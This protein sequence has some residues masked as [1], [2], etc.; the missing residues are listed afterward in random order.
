MKSR[1]KYIL[2]YFVFWVLVF[3]S[4]KPLFLLFH[5]ALSSD[6]SF[7][8]WTQV[9]FSGLSM[10]MSMS[11]YLLIPVLLFALVSCFIGCGK[12]F[13][14]S[15]QWFTLSML[16]VC[17]F[18]FSVDLFLYSYWGFRLDCTPLF[19][20]QSPKNA[21]AS[22]TA[23]EYAFCSLLFVLMLWGYVKLFKSIHN[24]FCPSEGKNYAYLPMVLLFI[25]LSVVTIRGGV[26]VS[27]MNVGRVYFS[28]HTF[29]N[30]AAIN[31][32]WN[33]FN[34]L[35]K[36]ED[37]VSDYRFMDDD[38]ANEIFDSLMI[39]SKSPSDTIVLNTSRPNIIFIV[40]ESFG[41]NVCEVVGG[42]PKLTPNLDKIAKEGLLFTHFYANSYRTDRGLVSIFSSYPGQPVT[43]LMKYPNKS[44]NVPTLPKELQKMGYDLSFCYGGDENFTNMRSYLLNAGFEKRVCDSDFNSADLSSKWGAYDH[45]VINRFVDDLNKQKETP[46][47]KVLLTLNSHEPFDV[48]FHKF[49][50]PY[51]NSVAYTDSCLGVFYDH[52]KNSPFWDN[53]LL[54]LL[55]DHARPYPSSMSNQE[56]GR[57]KAPLIWAGGALKK[58][59]VCES[60]GSQIDLGTTLLSQF[61]VDSIPF[62]FGK[63]MFSSK[64]PKYAFYAFNNGFGFVDSSGVSIFDC[65]GQMIIREDDPLNTEKGKAYLQ[66]LMEDFNKR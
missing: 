28:K 46:F 57:Y 51:P 62:K 37:F 10:D 53:T 14:S 1:T 66:L 45:V 56:E 26:G 18:A 48:P 5:H 2:V 23:L 7:A 15:L 43:S 59:G 47:F 64:A 29:L 36:S 63:N 40:L 4:Q 42:E 58:H 65:D 27:V 33:F 60:I 39:N 6:F 17:V 21:A 9:L 3:A 31:P 49:E 24:H 38:K 54:I 22:G 50:D 41:A 35:S 34:S 20:L 11:A 44:A 52:F 19:Y 55:P 16:A 13:K 8:E 61:G 25:A 32:V 30:H 12:W